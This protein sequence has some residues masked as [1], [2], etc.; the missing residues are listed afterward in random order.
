MMVG[1][2]VPCCRCV[3]QILFWSLHLWNRTPWQYQ[4]QKCRANRV[5]AWNDYLCLFSFVITKVCGKKVAHIDTNI[6]TICSMIGIDWCVLESH[7]TVV[8]VDFCLVWC[9]H[10]VWRHGNIVTPWSSRRKWVRFR[11]I[12]HIGSQ[13][14]EVIV[15][16]VLAISSFCDLPNIEVHQHNNLVHRF[17]GAQSSCRLIVSSQWLTFDWVYHT[18]SKHS[19]NN[20][21]LFTI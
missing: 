13:R 1:A 8:F 10:H 21:R 9:L 5:H 7:V 18:S 20:T 2:K 15:L 14:C 16:L 4:T 12:S 19:S 17:I 3:C 6:C 11:Q